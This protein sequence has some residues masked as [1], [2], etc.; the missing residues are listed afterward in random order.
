M[1]IIMKIGNTYLTHG[2][3]LAP[4][5]GVTDRSFR[6]VCRANGAEYTV[7]EMVSAKAICYEMLSK[8]KS[9]ASKTAPLA[10]VM[11]D[12]APMA[13]QIFGS[14]P[15]FMARAAALIESG[16][17]LG[18]TSEI[19]P[20]AIDI[21]MGCPVHKIVSNGEGSALMKNPILVGRIIEA[22]SRALKNIPVTVK[23]RAG[24]DAESIN[25]P[26]I[27]HIAQ[28]SGAAA[29]TVHARTKARMY[30]PGIL[31]EVISEV[32]KKVDIPVIGNGDIFTASDAL[33]MLKDTGCDGVMIARGALGNPWLFTEIVSALEGK[34]FVAPTFAKKMDTALAQIR[35]MLSE[36][37]ERVGI[38]EAKKHLAWYVKAIDG[39]ASARHRIMNAQSF[40]DFE[41]VTA[42]ILNRDK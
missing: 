17:Y 39:A 7:S 41:A 33:K 32:K 6:R 26:E 18:C 36:K 38:A 25:A 22:V 37:G 23:I 29:I 20:T 4:M 1:E 24:W 14:E 30:E 12:E 16:E 31:P 42:E 11:R 28:E 9:V 40:S 35:E 5:A 15:E 10:A 3:F 19:P 13:V 34:E 27:A 8:K 21:N 2:L